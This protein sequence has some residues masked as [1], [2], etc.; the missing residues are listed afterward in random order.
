M[1]KMMGN[2]CTVHSTTVVGVEDAEEE[3]FGEAVDEAFASSS[4][5]GTARAEAKVGSVDLCRD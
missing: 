4:G 5:C 1:R 2:G 3:S